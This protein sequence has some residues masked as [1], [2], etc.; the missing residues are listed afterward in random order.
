GDLNDLHSFTPN[1]ANPDFPKPYYNLN[2][3]GG[4]LSG[5]VPGSKKTFFLGSYERRWSL[6]PLRF[7]ANR[8]LP[9]Q[10]LLNGDF[11]DLANAIKPPVPADILPT[12]TP[13]ELANNT[14]LVGATRRFIT[15]PQ[16]LLNPT[17]AKFVNL[18]YPKS[19]LSAP[20]DS[21][22]RLLSFAQNV[23][24][25]TTRDLV[26][27]RVDHDFSA[28]DKFYAVYNFQDSS[29][30]SGAVA[31]AAY[32]AFGLREN[33]QTNHTLSLTYSRVF[34]Q[35]FVNELRGGFNRQKLYRH[36][37]QKL[38][39]FLSSIGFSDADIAAYG[40]IV[41][42]AALDTFGQTELRITNLQTL[43]NGGR[44]VDRRL[45]QDLMTFGD[46]ITWIT[47]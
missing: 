34:S 19:S 7:S 41:G 25:R 1:P 20:V 16:R 43:T 33:K 3:D 32:P 45:D 10:R 5:P 4:S 39:Q 13:T 28:N 30:E 17:T 42:P 37:P 29:G 35:S 15:I 6:T 46:T 12:L 40:A 9:G 24:Q 23:N 26:T 11:S 14:V 36:A 2:E 18:Y 8:R 44:S 27:A 47:G 21:L 38:N 22:G 31:G